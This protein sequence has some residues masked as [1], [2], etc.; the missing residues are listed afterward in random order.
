MIFMF[1]YVKQKAARMGDRRTV[2]LFPKALGIALT[3]ID[4]A[5]PIAPHAL[6]RGSKG[7]AGYLF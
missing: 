1:P 6:N 4:Q 2:P 5:P 3:E 7:K